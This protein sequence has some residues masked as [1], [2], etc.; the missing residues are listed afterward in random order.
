[1]RGDF[2]V[3]QVP[4]AGDQTARSP[5][6]R[7][8]RNASVITVSAT[9]H[10]DSKTPGNQTQHY[11]TPGLTSAPHILGPAKRT[12]RCPK[13]SSHARE[14]TIATISHRDILTDDRNVRANFRLDRRQIQTGASG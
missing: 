2:D 10:T 8:S 4:P 9:Q 14:L 7:V 1:L 11:K 5:D 12:Q 3:G 6:S 13:L